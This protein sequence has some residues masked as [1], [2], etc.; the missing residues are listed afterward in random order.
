[1]AQGYEKL[2]RTDRVGIT[3]SF[4]K[5]MFNILNQRAATQRT[6]FAEQVRILIE[7]GLESEKEHAE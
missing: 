1:M 5:E 6:S 4:E 2:P 7:W 3:I